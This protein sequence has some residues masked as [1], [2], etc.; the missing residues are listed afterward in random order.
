MSENIYRFI[1][2]PVVSE[3]SNILGEKHN[4]YVFLVSDDASKQ[5]IRRAVESI[6]SVSVTAVNTCRKKTIN[7]RDMRGRL[8]KV[9][10]HKKAYVSIAS[11]QEINLYSGL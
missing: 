9:R 3:K 2:A 7:K 8:R 10:G 11:G 4:Q 6:F 1:K 5:Q